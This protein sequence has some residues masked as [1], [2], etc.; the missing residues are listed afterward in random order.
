MPSF[1]IVSQVDMQEVRNA[2]D[3]SM[4]E[5]VNRYDFKGTDTLIEITD[6][7]IT[8]ESASDHRVEA[9]IDVLK[10]KLVKRK[11]S[12]KSISGGE[13]KPVGGARARAVFTFRPDDER[14][15]ADG[16]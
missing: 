4:R 10:G 2:V 12:L 14:V 15:A 11:V 5:V 16:D 9:A 6:D 8:V 1:D 7:G 3:Q 13:I